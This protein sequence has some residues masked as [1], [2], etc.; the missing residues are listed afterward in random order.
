M[1]RRVDLHHLIFIIEDHSINF[2][3]K[4]FTTDCPKKINRN[5]LLLL[6]TLRH[7]IINR[8]TLR[9]RIRNTFKIIIVLATL[10][11]WNWI[12]RFILVLLLLIRIWVAWSSIGLLNWWRRRRRRSKISLLWLWRRRW[13][14]WLLY[15]L[16]LRLLLLGRRRWRRSWSTNLVTL[17][18]EFWNRRRRRKSLKN[19]WHWCWL[20]CSRW[21]RLWFCSS[22][23]RRR[24]MYFI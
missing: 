11:L 9:I 18:V 10:S 19:R 17:T 22:R 8:D 13:W 21:R 7:R 6:F 24:L 1:F 5:L 4:I 20:I 2:L 14:W 15:R 12:R 3:L 16:L 23:W